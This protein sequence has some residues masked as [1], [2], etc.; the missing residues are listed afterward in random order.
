MVHG[1]NLSQALLE[2]IEQ[3]PE[4]GVSTPN[5]LAVALGDPVAARAVIEIMKRY[6]FR[7][8]ADRVVIDP[9]TEA[10]LFTDFTSD[11]PL[12]QLAEIQRG[13]AARISM[14]DDFSEAERF[15]G[16]DATYRDDEAFAACV[17]TDKEKKTLEY[18]S[19]HARVGF[20]YIPGYLMF[21]EAHA[22]EEAARF[23][24]GFDVLFV[25]GHGV[26]HPRGCGLAS[27]VGLDLDVPTIGVARRRLVG[28]V[29]EKRGEWAPLMLENEVVGAEIDAGGSVVYVSVGHKVSLDTSIKIVK[30]MTSDGRFPEPLR[31]A[32]IE[33]KRIAEQNQRTDC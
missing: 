12:R 18:A 31:R 2:L 10:E 29:G 33:A 25:N 27:C 16:V 30:M 5:A 3:I 15:A 26:A 20:P 14:R 17:V 13:M 9:P 6:E 22:V 1:V 4:G 19:T 11:E 32:H 7:D 21:R 8:V 23:V 24:S 28:D